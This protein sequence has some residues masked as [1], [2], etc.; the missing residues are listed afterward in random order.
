L[1]VRILGAHS[2]LCVIPFESSFA[3]KWPEPCEA[4]QNFFA[5]CDKLTRGVGK[6]RWVE[7]TP[8]HIYRVREILRY[9]P[10]AKIVL[11]LRDGRDVA[12]SIRD[13]YG[14][15]EAGIDRWIE[16]NRAG[17]PFWDNASVRVVRY[18]KL[19]SEFEPTVRAV[20]AFV[21]EAFEEAALRF[22]EKPLYYFS[23]RIEKPREVFGENNGLYRNW[24]MNQPL[25][26][27][28]GKWRA[29]AAEEKRLLKDRA[30]GMLVE[31]GYASDL[32]W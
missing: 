5:R 1:L 7:K 16:D 28:R 31:Y 29:L 10:A 13:R 24:Q 15:L 19:V 32:N 27:G 18:E 22:H 2:R 17:E 14:S 3:L 30:G 11:M 9:F 6:A 26:D 8:R 25:F 20:F 21:G 4:A 12:C 23:S